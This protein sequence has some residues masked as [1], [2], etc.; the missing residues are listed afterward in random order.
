MTISLQNKT[1]RR[2]C[3]AL[4]YTDSSAF[5]RFDPVDWKR[6]DKSFVHLFERA[7]DSC[8]LRGVYSCQPP[9]RP[10]DSLPIVYVCEAKDEDE[11]QKIHKLVWNQGTI[12]FLLVASPDT[13]RLYN[14][15]GFDKQKPEPFKS[16]PWQEV[17]SQLSFL[18][19]QS[20]DTG[21]VWQSQEWRDGPFQKSKRLDFHLLDNLI[22]LGKKLIDGG[23][24]QENAHGL[25]GKHIYLQYM[26]HRSFLTDRLLKKWNIRSNDV[27]TRKAT[28]TAI[29]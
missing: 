11:A 14:G 27:F 25:I 4:Q 22:H 8:N 7:V 12:P 2:L 6:V 29:S 26:R 16:I 15:F 18:H 13:V 10:T 23:L 1:T 24:D 19:C 3:N 9:N 20:L 28:L 17:E 21:E 5:T